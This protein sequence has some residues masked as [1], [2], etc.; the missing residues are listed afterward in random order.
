MI[1]EKEFEYIQKELEDSFAYTLHDKL[2]FIS[3][4]LSEDKEL[5]PILNFVNYLLYTEKPE[6][7]LT[8]TLD[9]SKIPTPDFFN[10]TFNKDIVNEKIDIKN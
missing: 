1:T 10:T 4:L 8:P 5:E 3:G 9:F 6:I 2:I 7:S